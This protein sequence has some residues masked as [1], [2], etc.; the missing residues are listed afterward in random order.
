MRQATYR[1][2]QASKNRQAGRGRHAIRQQTHAGPLGPGSKE[3]GGRVGREAFF[4]VG[5][6]NCRKAGSGRQTQ[7]TGRGRQK[8][9]EVGS[10]KQAGSQ[11]RRHEGKHAEQEGWQP[12]MEGSR[13]RQAETRRQRQDEA[14]WHACRN[15]KS[16]A[17]RRC[18]KAE[19]GR[20]AGIHAVIRAVMQTCTLMQT[21]KHGGTG[22][23]AETGRYTEA[24]RQV[25]ADSHIWPACK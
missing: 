14:G 1:S 9:A 8:Q 10:Q 21:A 18:R 24:C 13:G 17:V 6:E 23:Q 4:Q 3:E 5:T 20:Q 11:K 16:E 22:K 25:E 7:E 19:A 12:E 15:I 2:K